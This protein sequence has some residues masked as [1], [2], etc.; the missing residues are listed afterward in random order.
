MKNERGQSILGH[1]D[2]FFPAF[3]YNIIKRV[4]FAKCFGVFDPNLSY[5]F[6]KSVHGKYIF[7]GQGPEDTGEWH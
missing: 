7:A 2:Y 1:G 3:A 6:G 4:L 5:R